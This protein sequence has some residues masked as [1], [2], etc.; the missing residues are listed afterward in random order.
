[1]SLVESYLRKPVL[2][3]SFVL[4]AASIGIIAWFRLPVNL[5]PDSERPKIAVVTVWPGA[6]ADDVEADVTRRI[7]SEV[8][9]LEE[10]R[11]VT[12]TSRDEVSAVVVE[13]R[14]VK[15]LDAAATDVTNAIDRIRAQLPPTIRP[16]MLFK[17]SSATPAVMTLA[18]RPAKGSPLDL[19]MVREL[20]EN[21]IRDRLL[22]IPEVADVEVFGGHE[23]AIEVRLHRD[24]LEKYGLTAIDVQR[25]L[26]AFDV[27]QPIGLV[28][29]SEDEFLLK[30]AGRGE[31]PGEAAG[32][33]G[34]H[35]PGG[36]VHLGDV[37]TIRRGEVEPRSA[38]HG[39]GAPAIALN[40]QRSRRG[41]AVDTIA[42]VS[43]ALPELER[44]WPGIE[45][46]IP[47]NQGTLIDLSIS[48]MKDALR[49]AVILT[50]LVIFLFIGDLR[51]VLLT[52]ISIPFTYVLTFLVMWALGMEFNIVTLTATIIAVGM[53]V[54][55]TIVVLE[56]ID[57]H[58]RQLGE[59]LRPAVIGGTE[60][61]MLAI[62][63]G[64]YSLV[65][66]LVP[67]MFIGGYVQTVLRPFTI[68]LSVALMCSYVVSVTVI[69][70]LA[71]FILGMSTGRFDRP[72]E[73]VMALVDRFMVAP[74]RRF[75]GW[76]AMQGLRHR[77]VFL[78]IGVVLFVASA[79]QMP[80]IGRNLMPPMDTGIVVIRYETD[81][82][83]SIEESERVLT[84][85][86]EILRQRPEVETISSALGSEPAVISFGAERTARQGM[87]TV[88]LVDR[89]HRPKSIWEIEKEL[90]RKMAAIPGLA[91]L[92]V[93]EYGATPLSS[94]R[95]PVDV[96]ISGPDLVELDRIAKEV[97]H[98]LRENVRDLTSIRRSWRLDTLEA[99][100]RA[101]PEKFGRYGVS[102]AEVAAQLRVAVRGL[103]A[104]TLRV[105]NETGVPWIVQLRA[106][107]RAR[108]DQLRTFPIRTRHGVVPLAALG[109]IE[110]R[111]TPEVI[112]H[113]A[114]QRT[115][116]VQAYRGTRP[117]THLQEDVE[118]ALEGLELPPG[119]T[120]SH[121][122]EVKQ[123]NESFGRLGHAL[124]FALV[125]LYFALIPAFDSF[126]HPVT[127]MSAIPL[128]LIGA[129]WAMLAADKHGCMPS[130]MGMILLAGI[131]VKNSILLIDFTLEARKR[132]V[133]RDQ[134]LLDSVNVRTRPILMTAFSTV[135]GMIPVAMGWAIG[136][137]RLAPL[138]VVAIGGLLVATFLTMIYVPIFFTLFD[139]LA[140][141][142][143][144]RAAQ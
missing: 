103:P 42:A 113:Q 50:I 40:V 48:N 49:D 60:E 99:A 28:R 68:T 98:R 108:V 80:L 95:A 107:Q 129:A 5:F 143:R 100:F 138:A 131:V 83:S 101:D 89:F 118:R 133:A 7:E 10:V 123:M 142:F 35:R 30:R 122:G 139:D 24:L 137:E 20:A 37:A 58:Y 93:F 74:L 25:A 128:G 67:I 121:E 115:I 124:L 6:A 111:R 26:A 66:V 46:T 126:L 70:L 3:L 53:L 54:D 36:D 125:L 31:R 135:V 52:T 87:L 84:R 136:L 86:E 23:P 29:G 119:Y 59:E 116:D 105:P 32:S 55:D 73:R 41:N 94:I 140:G 43:R 39:N 127:I 141:L 33:G 61:V 77:L 19:S 91:A 18:L 2:V 97:E 92:D 44:D 110:L 1:M 69:P 120:I 130:M 9:G 102:P 106:D 79:R 88:H 85:I 13:F 71:P 62:L 17:I 134:A 8:Q 109:T 16:P 76:L 21:E 81:A 114:L 47:D 64:T 65:M 51:S 38:Y 82:N 90:R 11:L 96:M 112:T 22:A 117:I 78:A 75:Y 45:F 27:D 4:L 12:S 56:N 72:V 132:G 63:S 15:D 34:A 144:H 57:R 14:Y 104:A